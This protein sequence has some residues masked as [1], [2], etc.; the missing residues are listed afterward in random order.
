MISEVFK[1][2]VLV[3]ELIIYYLFPVLL[4]FVLLAP[5]LL[6]PS[7]PL[8][9]TH[10]LRRRALELICFMNH[11]PDFKDFAANIS[12]VLTDRYFA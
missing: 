11:C 1:N 5:P 2:V 9:A 6:A 12:T 7:P 10:P 3:L 8:P 4:L